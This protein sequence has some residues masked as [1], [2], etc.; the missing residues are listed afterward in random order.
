VRFG[1]S[2]SH[3]LPTVYERLV[4]HKCGV[5]RWVSDGGKAHERVS[6]ASVHGPST[7]WFSPA[8]RAAA[9]RHDGQPG[10]PAALCSSHGPHDPRVVP[11]LVGATRRRGRPRLAAKRGDDNKR[12]HRAV[13]PGGPHL[14]TRNGCTG[15]RRHRQ[16]NRAVP[17]VARRRRLQIACETDRPR[18]RQLVICHHNQPLGRQ[19]L[20]YALG[21]EEVAPGRSHL[22]GIHRGWGNHAVL[23][24]RSPGP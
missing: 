17:F 13:V 16:R 1:A 10:L 2:P 12:R 21:E 11:P 19:W 7:H 22:G 8:V 20:S 24:V 5:A 18:A 4:C 23:H 9:R 14:P 3:K 15:T 6:V